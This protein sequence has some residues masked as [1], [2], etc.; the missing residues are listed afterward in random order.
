MYHRLY[1]LT[2]G[3][4]PRYDTRPLLGCSVFNYILE[5]R[6]SKDKQ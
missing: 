3:Y 4:R 6:V 5:C 2:F 1:P